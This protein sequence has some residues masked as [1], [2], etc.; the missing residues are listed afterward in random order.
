V[1]AERLDGQVVLVT[2]ASRGIG[3]AVAVLCAEAGA[4]VAVAHH[5]SDEMAR[6]ADG[7]VSACRTAG[8]V[9]V[10][11]PADLADPDAADR[12]VAAVRVAIGPVT[13]LV[14]NAAASHRGPFH[15]VSTAAWDHVLQV[16]LRGTWALATAARA[17]LL[18]ARN[19]SIVV[20]SSVMAQ[21]ASPA[22]VAY[23][24]SK[25][26]LEGL[27]RALARELGPAGVRVNVVVPGAIRTEQEIE[28]G[29]APQT[30]TTLLDQQALKRR[31]TAQDVAE[32]IAFLTSDRAGFITG[33]SVRV[34][35]GLVMG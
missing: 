10:A 32:L 1:T 13:T 23:I 16:N 19:P 33:Q 4:A 2:G 7:V 24:S 31:G 26:G 34:D 12:L 27:T 5:P 11:V 29:P 15:E 35:G 28:S 21:T 8:A 25:A 17:D 3:A 9:A 18:A 20:V 6:L 14:C 30:I 22:S